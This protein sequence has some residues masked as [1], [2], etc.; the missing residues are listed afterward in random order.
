MI[1]YLINFELTIPSLFNIFFMFNLSFFLDLHMIYLF[2]KVFDI[3]Y[4][5]ITLLQA[6]AFVIII[7][8]NILNFK[9]KFFN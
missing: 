4:L 9:L 3:I 6:N 5:I 7:I 1:I 8:V 2:L